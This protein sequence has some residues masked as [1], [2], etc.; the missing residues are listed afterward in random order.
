VFIYFVVVVVA[1]FVFVFCAQCC[2]CLWVVHFWLFPSWLSLDMFRCI[3]KT[4][5]SIGL[6][7]ID[8]HSSFSK[9]KNK[10]SYWLMLYLMLTLKNLKVVS[11][12]VKVKLLFQ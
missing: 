11:D 10:L 1:L 4:L 6:L 9:M 5:W 3:S 2:Q 7:L 8:M 12:P